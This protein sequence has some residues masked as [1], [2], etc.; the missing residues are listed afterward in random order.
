MIN[1][2]IEEVVPADLKSFPGAFRLSLLR[3]STSQRTAEDSRTMHDYK[4]AE[5]KDA[6]YNPITSLQ[7]SMQSRILEPRVISLVQKS[8]LWLLLLCRRV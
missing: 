3:N 5:L 6:I 7:K 8:L 4:V 2:S 1:F